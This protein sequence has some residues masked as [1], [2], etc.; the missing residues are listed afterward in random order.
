MTAF[1]TGSDL[2]D[3][4]ILA[5]LTEMQNEGAALI[6]ADADLRCQKF[7]NFGDLDVDEFNEA[8]AFMGASSSTADNSAV[9]GEHVEQPT[10]G[11][12][13][14]EAVAAVKHWTQKM[15]DG[16]AAVQ[17]ADEKAKVLHQKLSVAVQ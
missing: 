1:P 10:S 4:A 16:R 3:T 14:D 5:V 12:S 17:N 8:V 15:H 7:P 13:Y 11:L 9:D 2:R 6:H